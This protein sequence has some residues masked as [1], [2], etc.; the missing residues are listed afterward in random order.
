M[1]FQNSKETNVIV[2]T[3]ETDVFIVLISN[4]NQFSHK[5]VYMRQHYD[6]KV[7][8]SNMKDVVT[9]LEVAGL[10]PDS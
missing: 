7:T 5:S 4:R 1:S 3:K 10:A 6:C 2:E 9:G 8:I